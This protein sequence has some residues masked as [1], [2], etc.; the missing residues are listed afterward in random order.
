MSNFWIKQPA[1]WNG[2][3]ST[4]KNTKLLYFFDFLVSILVYTENFEIGVGHAKCQAQNEAW[5]A[6]PG[7]PPTPILEKTLVSRNDF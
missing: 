2:N 3:R 1:L 7:D 6:L 4:V 5:G